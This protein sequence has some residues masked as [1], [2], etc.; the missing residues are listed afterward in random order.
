MFLGYFVYICTFNAV[1]LLYIRA[2]IRVKQ[3]PRP[4][5]QGTS[6]CATRG[7]TYII[8]DLLFVLFIYLFILFYLFYIFFFFFWGGGGVFNTVPRLKHCAKHA[9]RYIMFTMM[10]H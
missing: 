7:H 5:P 10:L 8:I 3:A 2:M 1:S 4:R 6:R 9:K